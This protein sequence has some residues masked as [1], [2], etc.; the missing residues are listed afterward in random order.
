[1]VN[2]RRREG[3]LGD[4][5]L[6]E[7]ELRGLL[8]AGELELPL[9]SG[10]RTAAR[11]LGL[12]G[13]GRR[14]LG[15]ARLVEGHT[16]AVAILAEAAR[17][18][19]SEALY[20]V[21]ASRSGGTGARLVRSDDGLALHGTVRFCS[22][23]HTIDRAL[24]V[25]D[26]P[27][28]ADGRVLVEIAVDQPG[29]V[30][31]PDT[32]ATAAMAA[33]DTVDVRFDSVPVSL[34]A[35][36]GPAGWYTTRPG[37]AA[38]GGGVAAVWW[39]GAAGLLDRAIACL[40][41]SADPHQLAHLGELHALM[42]AASALLLRTADALDA[43]PDADHTGSLA[44]VRCAVERAARE[45]VERVPRMVG[46]AALSRDGDLAQALADLS[47]YIRQHHGERD[48]AALGASVLAMR[49][50]R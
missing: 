49:G 21:W 10:G 13:W 47:L 34:D 18:A 43:A 19:R 5:A 38:G 42:E 35:L 32:W 8:S 25:A 11:W 44:V 4:V 31:E 45:V 6:V 12:A 20:G 46:A 33:A 9:P 16:D 37:F 29:L 28:P 27:E 23:A 30:P 3:H 14:D 2:A 22:G 17:Q 1:M 48:H 41:S 15:L 50:A 7:G 39:G 26:A 40:R 36:I 24:V